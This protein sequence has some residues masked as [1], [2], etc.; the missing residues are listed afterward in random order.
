MTS[1]SPRRD[2]RAEPDDAAVVPA[3]IATA[4]LLADLWRKHR[5]TN[6]ER[7]G[8]LEEA[9]LALLAGELTDSQRERALSAAHKLAG[10][11]GSFGFQAGTD[12]AREAERLLESCDADGRQLAELV[13][14]LQSI[15][16][17]EPAVASGVSTTA[18]SVSS[19]PSGRRAIVHTADPQFAEELIVALQIVGIEAVGS[20]NADEVH[21]LAA[22]ESSQLVIVDLMD[23]DVGLAMLA[24]LAESPALERMALTATEHI[25]ERIA[26]AR[27]GAIGYI[28]RA[29]PA[30][31][32]A[33]TVDELA[34]RRSLD[35]ATVLVVDRDTAALDD[36][37]ASL[38]DE[39]VRVVPVGEPARF[40]STLEDNEPEAVIVDLASPDTIGLEL[41][42][43]VRADPRWHRLPV[44]VLTAA[45]DGVLREAYAAG[46]DEC[47]VKPLAGKELG[48]RVAAHVDRHRLFVAATNNDPVTG[49]RTRA[50]SERQ[51][52][53]L[54]NLA[55]RQGHSLT[56]ALVDLVGFTKVVN[57]SGRA[58]AEV[59]LRTAAG[60]LAE[61]LRAEDVIGRWGEA[62][63]V[64]GLIG[65]EPESATTRLTG[66]VRD[67]NEHR[68]PGIDGRELTISVKAGVAHFPT[69]G[70]DVESV[71]RAA[72]VAL[73]RSARAATD[74][75]TAGT[76]GTA[77]GALQQCDVVIV[78]D[79]QMLAD[80][81]T[82]TLRT[83]GL[84]VRHLADGLEAA[85]ALTS[86]LLRTRLV[87]LDVG[88]PGLD[89]FGVL[90]R[91]RDSGVLETTDVVML[92]ARSAASETLEALEL[93]AVNHVSKPFSVPVLLGRLSKLLDGVRA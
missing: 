1:A 24:D 62:T 49:V 29:L 50:S 14:G 79:D 4:N 82:H 6:V 44:L 58:C 2:D 64:V 37:E 16:E 63:L 83:Q 42:R 85:D 84:D 21:R 27:S 31:R 93:G 7:V 61:Q 43:M 55:G 20:D 17:E 57:Q 11:L 15:V 36:L 13:V 89:G 8:E 92:T 59:A 78:D 48:A 9:A 22:E 86:G 53:R 5:H 30:A 26:V 38:A 35:A 90:R 10:S 91:L 76:S 19:G 73:R 80:L 60:I 72:D 71:S 52:A 66:L 70:I 34:L 23:P 67:L 65:V 75:F 41:C 74:V 45:G 32:L 88:L 54:I 77:A 3:E 40:W 46:V 25:D 33:A 47:I 28:P 56:I 39:G 81:L 69:D 18:A 68:F 51:L 87:L 12:A